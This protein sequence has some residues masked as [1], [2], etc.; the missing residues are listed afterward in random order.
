MDLELGE[1]SVIIQAL[2]ANRVPTTML[3]VNNFLVAFNG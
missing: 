3:T 1:L 2:L